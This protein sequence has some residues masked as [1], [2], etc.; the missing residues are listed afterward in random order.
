M[1]VNK[2]K[3][4]NWAENK[5]KK[6]PQYNNTFTKVFPD[7]RKKIKLSKQSEKLKQRITTQTYNED[8]C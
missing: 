6:V 1:I 5:R 2:K 3:I 4:H 8:W 7:N